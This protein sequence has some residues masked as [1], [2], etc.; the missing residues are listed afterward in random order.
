MTAAHE[1]REERE[2]R[3]EGKGARGEREAREREDDVM[4]I[5]LRLH[6]PSGIS[7]SLTDVRRPSGIKHYQQEDFLLRAAGR[8]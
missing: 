3:R 7:L 4:L 2:E 1:R 6:G 8:A 5:G